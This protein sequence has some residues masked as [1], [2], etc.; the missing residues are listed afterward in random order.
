MRKII[1]I[2][3]TI[4]MLV[5][6]SAAAISRPVFNLAN[7]LPVNTGARWAAYDSGTNGF[8][9][10]TIAARR[11]PISIPGTVSNLQVTLVTGPGV[12]T[13]WDINLFHNNA[14][15]TIGCTIS[16]TDT[17][18]SDTVNTVTVA[19]GDDLA[20]KVTPINSPISS[21]MSISSAFESTNSGETAISGSMSAA[22]NCLTTPYFSPQG[23]VA[24][25]SETAARSVVPTPF[26]L[27]KFYVRLESGP[28]AGDSFTYTVYKNGSATGLT[29]SISGT[30][31]D[32]SDTT[33]SVSFAA[34]DYISVE[35]VGAGTP[36]SPRHQWGFRVTPTTDG[37]TPIFTGG[38]VVLS[39]VKR[40]SSV[41][42]SIN[43]ASNASTTEYKSPIAFDIKKAYA[44]I[45]PAQAATKD[46]NFTIQ[47]NFTDGS[48]SPTV[49]ATNTE[50]NDTTNTTS[51]SAGDFITW[52]SNPTSG[53]TNTTYASISA[54]VY[55]APAGGG[56]VV[57]NG[58]MGLVRA[59]IF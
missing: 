13:Q 2:L 45:F 58:L 32:N 17:S 29:T 23:S 25:S 11:T 27:D 44:R 7:A 19:E 1:A 21:S 47:K 6:L 26:T 42:G 28:G 53:G 51:F 30:N 36:S 33:N 59:L 5:P 18:C 56:G 50:G 4:L 3:A 41:V 20:W 43:N 24:T 10:N 16:G 46:W 57:D 34:G 39:L 31:V 9:S 48:L 52:E 15:S 12:G 54:V 55:V 38:P 49:L 35:C 40:W 14:T 37:E 22:N 8:N